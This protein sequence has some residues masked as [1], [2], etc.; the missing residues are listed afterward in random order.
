MDHTI[1]HFDIPANDVEKLKKF[2]A[3]LFQ[4]KYQKYPGPQAYYTLETVPTDKEGRLVRPGVNGGIYARMTPSDIPINYISVE[5]IDEYMAKVEKL[6]GKMLT[7]KMAISKEIGWSA[8][9]T[10]PEGNTFGL[11]QPPTQASPQAKAKTAAKTEAKK[12]ASKRK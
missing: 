10:D 11:F 2:Y 9:A 6:G 12:D 1:V 8:I 3:E 7:P 4:W 5:S